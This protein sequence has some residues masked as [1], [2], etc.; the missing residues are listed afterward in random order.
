[1]LGRE[2]LLHYLKWLGQSAFIIMR[3]KG[4][5]LTL[6]PAPPPALPPP[7]PEQALK[8]SLAHIQDKLLAELEKGTT[9]IHQPPAPLYSP[10]QEP[11]T[12]NGLRTFIGRHPRG[13]KLLNESRHKLVTEKFIEENRELQQKRMLDLQKKQ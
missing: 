13:G 7:T 4:R 10:P 2:C 5:N 8:A 9:C 6:L 1:M 11:V 12:V 3:N